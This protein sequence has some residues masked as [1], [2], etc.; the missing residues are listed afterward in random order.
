[1]GAGAKAPSL[2][3]PAYRM[4][5]AILPSDLSIQGH[6]VSHKPQTL[7]AMSDH[8]QSYTRVSCDQAPHGRS[9]RSQAIP[10]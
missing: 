2:T 3:L 1:M 9:A 4:A 5:R 10:A 7:P 6:L 8:R